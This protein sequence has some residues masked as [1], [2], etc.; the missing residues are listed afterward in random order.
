MTQGNYESISVRDVL[1]RIN[2]HENG[3]FLPHIQRQYVWGSRDSSEEY[4]CLLVDSLLRGFPIGGLVLW[5][6]N[7]KIPYR[8]FLQDYRVGT[9]TKIVPEERQ[10]NHKFLVYDG[11]QRLQTLYSVLFY[12]FNGRILYYDL[13]FDPEDKE[14]DETGFFFRNIGETP[15]PNTISMNEL[16]GCS[17]TRDK[18]RLRERITIG[19]TDTEQELVENNFENLWTVFVERSTR[20]IAYFPVK[21]EKS[22]DVN[23]VFRRLNTGGIPLTQLEMV[24]AKIKEKYVYFEE[25]LWDLSRKITNA[26]SS[27]PGYVFSAHE[28]VQLIYLLVLN[29]ARVDVDKINEKNVKE[30]ID[31]FSHVSTVLPHFF[32]YFLFEGFR[33]N[34]KWLIVRQQALL[35]LMAYCVT[36]EKRGFRWKD[37]LILTLLSRNF[38]I[39]IPKQW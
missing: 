2:A 33:I 19:L 8:E 3:W 9:V 20:S 35:P 37:H 27:N 28:I 11:Q 13:K 7:S 39:G 14:V 5:E 4:I 23:E 6:T 25:D 15:L 12:S 17:T 31:M 34:A 32:K 10:G 36:L 21:S 22:I 18:I 38:V 24:L 1:D 29:T 16:L 30:M 26:T